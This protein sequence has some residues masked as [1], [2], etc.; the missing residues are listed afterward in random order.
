MVRKTKEEAEKTRQQIIAAARNVFH[1]HGVS[2][3]SLS[4][5]A[6]AAG[7]TRGAVYWHFEDKAAL[8]Y[9]LHQE[10]FQPLLE[11]GDV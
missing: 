10:T 4:Q 8:F 11:R 3:A 5:V 9:A 1:E 6:V 2:N 7:V